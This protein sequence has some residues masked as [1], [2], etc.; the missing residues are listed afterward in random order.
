MERAIVHMNLPNFFIACERL[1][2][3]SLKDVPLIIS[4][5][6][7]RGSVA[8]CSSEAFRFGVRI[9]M[10][11]HFAIKLCPN[12]KLLK[13]DYDLYTA[14]SKEITEIINDKAPVVE[15]SSIQSFY[16]DV[17]GM[18]RFFGCFDWT[19]ELSSKVLHE[20]GLIPSWALSVNKTVSRIGAGET[21]PEI[22]MNIGPEMVRPFLNP[23]PVQRLPLIGD[24]TFQLFSRIGIRSIGK[25]AEMPA[26]VLQK[27]LGNRGSVIW[28]R[29]NGID[30]DPVEPY[31]EKKAIFLEY[32]FERDCIDLGTIQGVLMGMVERLA[33][34]LRADHL[35]TSKVIVKVKYNNLDTET[36]QA[37][38][39]YTSLDHILKK[40]VLLLF[41]KL[42]HRRMRLVRV[43]VRLS[44]LVPGAHQIDLFEDTG[45]MLSLYAALD[46][47]RLKYGIKSVGTST[48][49]YE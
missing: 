25:V 20:S 38:I 19:K 12:A 21:V 27:M 15:K 49:F 44:E 14:K 17:T 48:A 4:G 46:T 39:A 26:T 2:D 37:K 45:E 7:D 1:C 35:L 30:R 22:P 33:F 40:E 28:Q 13:G 42:Y 3:S 16:L 24:I 43:G 10:P 36:K 9:S 32:D 11:T 6:R 5:G 34:R 23:L 47:I 8:A 31:S 29:A 18:D 41:N